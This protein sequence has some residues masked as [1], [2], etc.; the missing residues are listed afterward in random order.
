MPIHSAAVGSQTPPQ[1]RNLLTSRLGAL[2][3]VP[4]PIAREA[5]HG[6]TECAQIWNPIPMIPSSVS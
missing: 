3:R 4:I 1:R 5:L 6:Y 2:S